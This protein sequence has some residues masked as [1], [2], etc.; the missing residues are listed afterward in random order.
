MRISYTN[1]SRFTIDSA[2]MSK[3]L[4]FESQDGLAAAM[5]SV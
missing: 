3:S 4:L 1:N 2:D 5:L